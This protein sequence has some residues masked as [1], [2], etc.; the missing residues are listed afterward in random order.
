MNYRTVSKSNLAVLQALQLKHDRETPINS[1]LQ[2]WE[3]VFLTAM[4]FDGV[5]SVGGYLHGYCC[6]AEKIDFVSRSFLEIGATK[7]S[8]S[9]LVSQK[10]A[11]QLG[12]PPG[13]RPD[14]SLRADAYRELSA[15]CE[16]LP[17]EDDDTLQRL[18]H[19]YWT[20]K[21]AT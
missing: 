15:F 21:N 17:F 13:S 6:F 16:T 10:F 7:A 19:S 11:A 4:E 1:R 5:S 20:A 8:E 3:T 12:C 18:Y 9:L 14:D 2:L